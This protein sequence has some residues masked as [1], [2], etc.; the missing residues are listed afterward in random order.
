MNAKRSAT[1]NQRSAVPMRYSSLVARHSSLGFT[2]IELM[3]VIG[4]VLLLLALTVGVTA[5][6]H[7]KS[8]V[9]QTENMLK[10]LDMALTSWE[11]ATERQLTYG[12][13]GDPPGSKY[14]FSTGAFVGN[15]QKLQSAFLETLMHSPHVK[16]ILAQISPDRLRR[17]ETTNEYRITDP[18]DQ[19]IQ[20]V[21]PG[22][23]WLN[24]DTAPKDADGTIRT[25][26]GDPDMPDETQ[27]GAC[28]NK[29]IC[30][31]SYGP[32]SQP[33]NADLAAADPQPTPALADNIES[34]PLMK[35]GTP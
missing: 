4:I 15:P 2:L 11:T 33:G 13:N 35:E 30:F 21:F 10:L 14:D 20:I 34:Y 29:R 27:L 12:T 16:D 23:K 8:D 17:D 32:D 28:V 18:W 24:I 19:P 7:R 31:V 5:A 26:N 1:S 6:L 9:R 22:R 25:S 3:V